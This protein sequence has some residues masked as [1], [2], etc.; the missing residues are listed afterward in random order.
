M[1]IE[2]LT[3]MIRSANTTDLNP[4]GGQLYMPNISQQQMQFQGGEGQS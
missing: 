1:S 4:K 3:S 2:N